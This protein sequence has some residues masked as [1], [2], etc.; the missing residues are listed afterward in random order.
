MSRASQ[1]RLVGGCTPNNAHCTLHIAHPTRRQL[2]NQQERETASEN[3]PVVV[4]RLVRAVGGD[5]VRAVHQEALRRSFAVQKLLA[6]V[7]VANHGCHAL[8]GRRERV[9]LDHLV[10]LA[11][12]E[13]V[14]PL[15]AHPTG[16]PTAASETENTATQTRE[17]C[18]R[19]A[20][21]RA[22]EVEHRSLGLV[23]DHNRPACLA[24]D[25]WSSR[26]HR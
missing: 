8:L 16:H 22:D 14:E 12:R 1:T 13:V 10:L 24:V 18:R 11:D 17:R 15:R 9:R 7:R 23:S 19:I 26:R 21:Q 20:H 3:A 25:A 4:E 2:S 5:I 6:G